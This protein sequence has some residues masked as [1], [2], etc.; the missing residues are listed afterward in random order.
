LKETS[1]KRR[2]VKLHSRRA[3]IYFG[4]PRAS[5]V[6]SWVLI[7]PSVPSVPSVP[8][9]LSFPQFLPFSS[10]SFLLLPGLSSFSLLFLLSQGDL[11]FALVSF[12]RIDIVIVCVSLFFFPSR[13]EEE[14][15]H[16]HILCIKYI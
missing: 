9:E 16:T 4:L 13:E 6:T 15:R 1:W 2:T 3:Q 8:S 10:L 12:G 7:F 5:T 14:E 11:F